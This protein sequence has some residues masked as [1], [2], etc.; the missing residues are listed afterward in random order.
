M[1]YFTQNGQFG[2]RNLDGDDGAAARYT[3]TKP[4]WWWPYIFTKDDHDLSNPR[5]Y[6]SMVIDEGEECE[7]VVLLPILPIGLIN[8]CVGIGTGHS[9]TIQN[10]NPLDICN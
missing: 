3:S 4:E 5:D 1:P 6:L 2:T 10:Y 7:P 9:T 8:G